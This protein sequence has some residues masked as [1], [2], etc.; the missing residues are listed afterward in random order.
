MENTAFQRVA[1]ERV[2]PVITL[3]D[4]A[5]AVPLAQA[6][7]EGGIHLLELP[8]RT[9]AALEA[10]RR[11]R[12]EVPG[13]VVGAGTVLTPAQVQEAIEVGAQ[14]GVAPGLNESV[15]RAAGDAGLPFVPGVIT[16]SEIE[17]ALSLDCRL[18]KF[19]PAEPSGGVQLLKNVAAPFLHTGVRF[20]PLGGL[21]PERAGDYLSLAAV[22]AIGGSWLA[23][24]ET[25][26]RGDWA[27]VTTRARQVMELATA[28]TLCR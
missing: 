6:L 11:V 9:P 17:H 3:T 12:A 4:A 20:I 27:T 26:A 23:D 15:V 21:T 10:I 22:A 13:T 14:F 1:R 5:Y 19:F 28:L 24:N 8:L 16:A 2:V 25:M 18:L 7:A